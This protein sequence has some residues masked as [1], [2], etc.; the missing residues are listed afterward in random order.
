MR[1]LGKRPDA[2][3]AAL[4]YAP[5]GHNEALLQALLADQHGFCAYSE[6]RITDLHTAA[7]EHFD[8]RLKGTDA[9]GPDNHY[10]V[11][12]VV[13]Q[14]KRR[15]EK[16]F[17]GAAFFETRFFQEPGALG[18]RLRYVPEA[19]AFDPVDPKDTEAAE[20]AE[21]LGFDEPEVADERR[22]HVQRLEALFRDAAWDRG[23]Q[24]QWLADHPEDLSYP[25]ALS[26][27]LE[28]DLDVLIEG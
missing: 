10:G 16:R 22:T 11:L 1:F 2:K 15:R 14:R 28:L 13:N 20:L 27:T 4:T 18:K 19:N 5:G 24:L 17:A 9:D 12:Q 21:Y 25:T 7:V 3:A 26:A 23:R 8:K 6:C